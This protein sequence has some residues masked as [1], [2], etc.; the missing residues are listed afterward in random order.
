M[1]EIEKAKLEFKKFLEEYKNQ[2]E[3]GF[4]LKVIHTYQVVQ[5][6][7][8][9]AEKLNLGQEDIELAELI[10]LLHDIGRFEELKMLSKFD[11]TN[12]DHAEH[13]VKMLFENNLIRKFVENNQYDEIIK[14]AIQNH[15]KLEIEK[16]LDERTLLHCKI[17]RDSDKL[18]NFRVK[19]EERIEAMFPKIVRTKEELENAEISESVYESIKK[20]ECVKL[21]D[22]KTPLDYLI[23]ILAFAF[24]LNFSV[25]YQTVKNHDYMNH[26]I[27]R[28]D[29]KIPETKEK[30][31]E[32]RRT[33]NEYI[34]KKIERK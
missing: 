8:T 33:L 30:M 14:Q 26:L 31:E 4:E 21:K 12:F 1:I 29:Y 27:D 2:E 3:L 7:K 17:I 10:G 9:L 22:R 11:S 16:G 23:C 24:D 19:Q 32:I 34:A 28:F 18:D 15:N 13:G 6:S 5:N 20:L 25:S